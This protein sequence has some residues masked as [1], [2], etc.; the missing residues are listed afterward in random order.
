MIAEKFSR[1]VA[2]FQVPL[3]N[4]TALAVCGGSGMDAEF[5]ARQGMTVVTADISLNAARRARARALRYGLSIFPVVADA[6][7]LPF[8]DRAVD[9]VY[10][11]DGLHHLASPDRGLEEAVRVTRSMVSLTE[12]AAALITRLAVHAGVAQTV[13]DAGNTVA[14][15]RTSDV[16]ESLTLAGFQSVSCKRYALFYRHEPGVL[17][18]V[19]SRPVLFPLAQ[20]LWKTVNLA[21]GRLG[22]KLAV[23]ATRGSST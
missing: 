4:Q 12:P 3:N 14:R 17:M 11:H 19:F 13:E 1:S 5:L 9:L 15:L 7:Q 2:T 21:A 18:R 10:V 20:F 6:E 23:Q 22:N 16:R 8:C